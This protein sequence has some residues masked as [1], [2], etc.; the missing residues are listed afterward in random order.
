[1]ARVRLAVFDFDGVLTDNRVYVFED[2]REAVA[3]WRSDGFGL[4][5][6]QQTGVRVMVLSTEVNPVV[7]ARCRKLKLDC[8]QGHAPTAGR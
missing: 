7:S 5:R 1:M 6:L 8:V 2:G 3:C 4:V